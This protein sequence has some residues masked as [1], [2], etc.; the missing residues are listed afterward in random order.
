MEIIEARDFT[1][2][3]AWG[4]RALMAMGEHAAR[5]HWTDQPYRWH[6]NTGDELFVVLD[7][8]VDMHYVDDRGECQVAA[9]QPGQMALMKAGD[10][11]VA[12]PRGA[13]RILVVERCDSV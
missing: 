9:L 3:R 12:H 6:Q 1:A 7:G 8:I 5:L 2:E 4:S 10:R 13:A 11:H